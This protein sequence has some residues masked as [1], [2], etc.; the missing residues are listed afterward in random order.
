MKAVT[1]TVN[2]VGNLGKDPQIMNFV[3]GSKKVSATLATSD[4][5][6]NQKGEW[7]KDVQ[8]HN[9]VAWGKTAEIMSKVLTKGSQVAV[10]GSLKYRTYEDADGKTKYTTEIVVDEFILGGKAAEKVA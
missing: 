4:Y 1:N 7:V 9:L 6:K 10:Q 5:F 3:S 8:W 2:L